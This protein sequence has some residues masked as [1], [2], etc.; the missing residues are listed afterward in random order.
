MLALID[1][2]PFGNSDTFFQSDCFHEDCFGPQT[3]VFTSCR[4]LWP[5]KIT[6]MSTVVTG[7]VEVCTGMD[8][9]LCVHSHILVCVHFFLIGV[10]FLIR[11]YNFIGRL[12]SIYWYLLIFLIIG[13]KVLVPF[14][15]RRSKFL[16]WLY[17][18]S[19]VWVF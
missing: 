8:I 2:L 11:Y 9:S 5:A 1:F 12:F 4:A 15:G 18:I 10:R 3:I 7:K 16:L 14:Y 6:S 13:I 19:M 17:V